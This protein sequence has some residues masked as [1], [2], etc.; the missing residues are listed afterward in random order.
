VCLETCS[1]RLSSTRFSDGQGCT[2]RCVSE[3]LLYS[4]Q[5]ILLDAYSWPA[6]VIS[7]FADA[8]ALRHVSAIDPGCIRHFARHQD[9]WLATRV[10]RI[11][12]NRAFL[13]VLIRNCGI[14]GSA[15]DGKARPGKP[16]RPEPRRHTFKTL[17]AAEP[18]MPRQLRQRS[19]VSHD[20]EFPE[21][22]C[23]WLS[24]GS[25]GKGRLRMPA[26]MR[27]RSTLSY[28][29]RKARHGN[30]NLEEIGVE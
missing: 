1:K 8:R 24:P 23:T 4:A 22:I 26:Q 14:P 29:G 25:D 13:L 3:S 27:S 11:T 15:S 30:D 9:C 10:R 19:L 12:P 17:H 18:P 21:H 28:V 2:R 5:C 6:G 20:E 16:H 7:P